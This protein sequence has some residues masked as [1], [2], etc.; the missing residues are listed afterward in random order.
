MPL[1]IAPLL[2]ISH[3]APTFALEPGVLG[4]ELN[5]IG[6]SLTNINAILV[7]SPHWQTDVLEVMTTAKPETIHDFY[8]FPK[9]LYE[10]NYPALGSPSV[11]SHVL[12]V[13]KQAGFQV[14]ENNTRGLDHGAW[15]P[16]MHL[17]PEA[18]LP[19]FQVSLPHS[20]DSRDSYHLGQAI[21]GLRSEG[22]LLLCSGS[23][24]HNLS[25]LRLGSQGDLPYVKEFSAWVNTA[26]VEDR[27]EELL[28]YRQC[29][30]NALRAHPTEEHFLPL[31]IALGARFANDQ[32][33]M[34]DGGISYGILAMDAL[35]WN[36]QNL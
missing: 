19:V 4:Q 30:P 22:V 32:L 12:D 1:P 18:N 29:A 34:I 14:H 33:E 16:L 17:L 10:L 5:M 15:T 36:N 7:V 28:N 13:L 27:L 2:F 25:D 3:G 20:F 8:G 24:T 26:I 35:L 23:M 11:A 21:A 6:K 31:F 9:P